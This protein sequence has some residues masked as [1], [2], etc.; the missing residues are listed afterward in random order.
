MII[1]IFSGGAEVLFGNIKKRD[2]LLEEEKK[3]TG[4]YSLPLF[5][6]YLVN[7]LF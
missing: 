3:C 5:K 7:E 2:V 6:S 1:G 4:N